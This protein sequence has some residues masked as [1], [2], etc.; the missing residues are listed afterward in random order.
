IYSSSPRD[1]VEGLRTLDELL[2][3]NPLT[4]VIIVSGNSE[5]QN[6][7]RAMERGAFDIFPKPISLDDLKVV[8]Q[9]AY[10]RVALEKESAD[11]RSLGNSV[12]FESI[13]GSS[14]S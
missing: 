2:A 10:R 14:P 6:A 12:P 5:R 8:L 11:E 4:K 3:M 9:R 1:A 7:L 13:I